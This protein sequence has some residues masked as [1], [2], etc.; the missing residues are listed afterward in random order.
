MRKNVTMK[1]PDTHNPHGQLILPKSS[2]IHTEAIAIR[3]KATADFNIYSTTAFATLKS[4]DL[5]QLK[6]VEV[7]AGDEILVAPV[8]DKIYTMN[9]S[10][11]TQ[12]NTGV[13]KVIT[14]K[15]KL[16]RDSNMPEKTGEFKT[17]Q[18]G[19]IVRNEKMPIQAIEIE[20]PFKEALFPHHPPC[21]EDIT[22]GQYGDCYMLAGALLSI[23]KK[24]YGADYIQSI[25]H[26]DIDKGIV[27]VRLYKWSDK[28]EKAE[29][30]YI[31]VPMTY[32]CEGKAISRHNAPWVHM[33]EKAYAIVKA[34]QEDKIDIASYKYAFDNGGNPYEAMKIFT[35]K[36]ATSTLLKTNKPAPWGNTRDFYTYHALV[37]MVPSLEKHIQG[38]RN[39]ILELLKQ[40][41]DF[42]QKNIEQ[43]TK[44]LRRYERDFL[45]KQ[46]EFK[47]CNTEW[48]KYL[49]ELPPND[50]DKILNA[51]DKFNESSSYD[52]VLT[53]LALINKEYGKNFSDPLALEFVNFMKYANENFIKDFSA[54]SV[55]PKQKKLYEEF[56]DAL[57]NGKLITGATPDYKENRPIGL[58]GP[59]AYTITAVYAKNIKTANNEYI[60]VP[61]VRFMNPWA[62]RGPKLETRTLRENG[63]YTIVEEEKYGEFEYPLA[64]FCQNFD[65]YTI[66]SCFETSDINFSGQIFRKNDFSWVNL[67]E[68]DCRNSSFSDAKL[69]HTNCFNTNFTGIRTNFTQTDVTGTDFTG[70]NFSQDISASTPELAGASFHDLTGVETAIWLGCNL[71]HTTVD[72]KF[73][74]AITPCLYKQLHDFLERHAGFEQ[75]K[76][77]FNLFC[78]STL[79]HVTNFFSASQWKGL[80]Y[81]E[82]IY[83]NALMRCFVVSSL[84]LKDKQQ[85]VAYVQAARPDNLSKE[86]QS[87]VD[88]LVVRL[89]NADILE[90]TSDYSFGA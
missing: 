27:T 35:G 16:A 5:E 56:A 17:G 41:E 66:G 76:G 71:L 8:Y 89:M 79:A 84:T 6:I 74:K 73:K 20:A 50:R 19:F 43:M 61:M 39:K 23:L 63:T 28:P 48:N 58:F 10:D 51:F 37:V 83:I 14:F 78:P 42:S 38:L 59:H 1:K 49:Y 3:Y 24:P 29:P 40:H 65:G 9:S 88:P 22:Q 11:S 34:M 13:Y 7:K 69:H 53:L 2:K 77:L 86:V 85:Y 30:I 15:K 12:L 46:R 60:A 68:R 36:A 31:T 70:A 81:E 21:V 25:M 64:L 54:Y 55:T 62:K 57:K 75:L 47:E 52:D 18:W 44:D 4:H 32:H 90:F 82:L 45:E 72:D 80:N 26:Q 67:M 33:L 87:V